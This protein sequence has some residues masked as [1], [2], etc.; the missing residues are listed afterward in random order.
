[1][2]CKP[3]LHDR[4]LVVPLVVAD[5]RSPQYSHRP[6]PSSLTVVSAGPITRGSGIRSISRAPKYIY[7]KGLQ[8]SVDNING[9]LAAGP[10]VF[11][12]A[13]KTPLS[14]LPTMCFGSMPNDGGALIL[15]ENDRDQLIGSFPDADSFIKRF[16]GASEYIAG[17]ERYAL[18]IDDDTWPAAERIAPI[19]ARVER[20][21]ILREQS[22][23]LATKKACGQSVSVRRGSTS[24]HRVHHGP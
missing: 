5:P 15:T 24:G 18:W 1:M 20:V 4:G 23:R 10:D 13:R 2:R 16:L 19:K 9:Y 6:T 3:F 11:V 22:G 8:I 17:E 7:D 12:M 14:D 21:R